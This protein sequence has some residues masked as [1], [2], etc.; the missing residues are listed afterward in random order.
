MDGN[1]TPR[2][3]PSRPTSRQLGLLCAAFV[4]GGILAILVDRALEDSG[5]MRAQETVAEAPV[6]TLEETP[7]PPVEVA[8]DRVRLPGGFES[9][10]FHAGPVFVFVDAGQVEVE[11]EGQATEYGPG[12][13]FFVPGGEVYTLSVL[14]TA[15]L[16][17]VR[18]LEP[19]AEPTTEVG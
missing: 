8:A 9:R 11:R 2:G 12:A 3:R 7:G 5:P 1:E 16:S 13:F 17:T 15:V 6:G 19:G 4:L 14:D 10:R 18:L